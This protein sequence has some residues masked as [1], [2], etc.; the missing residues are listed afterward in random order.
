MS[1]VIE[2]GQHFIYCLKERLSNHIK[3]KLRRVTCQLGLQPEEYP[4]QTTFLPFVIL[5]GVGRS[6]RVCLTRNLD[7]G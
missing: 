6:E 1:S 3:A 5:C 4:F 7:C 2:P